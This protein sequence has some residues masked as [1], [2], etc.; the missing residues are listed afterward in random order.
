[1]ATPRDIRRLALVALYQLDARGDDDTE[2]IQANIEQGDLPDTD[3]PLFVDTREPFTAGD[4]G[5]A[6]NLAKAAYDNTAVADRDLLGLTPDWPP[7]RQA[8]IDRAILRLAHH[9]MSSGRTPAKVAINE[10]V[11]LAKAFSTERSPTFI[12]GV[13]GKLM[14]VLGISVPAGDA[15]DA[16]T[17][18]ATTDP[19]V[20]PLS[21]GGADDLPN[22]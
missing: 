16:P 2:A 18:P 15:A 10:A 5:K 6:F 1:M 9:E 11:E 7:H 19:A 4:R 20:T 8:A 17:E 13:L 22:T 12:N 3:G 14:K 21:L